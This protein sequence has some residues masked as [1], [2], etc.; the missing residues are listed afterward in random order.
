VEKSLEDMGT[1]EIFLNRTPMVYAL[2]SR[3]NKWDLIKLQSFCNAKDTVNRT[4]Q[5]PRDW[6]NVFTNPTSD[7]RLIS[8]IYKELKKLDPRKSINPIKKWYIEL[9]REFSTEEYRMTEKYLKKCSTSLVIRG[10]QIK[11]TLRF[12]LT[13]VRMTKIKNSDDNRF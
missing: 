4:K 11:T 8:N 5:Q 7:R 9:N 2:K 13:P 3:I 1:G 10:M 6:E 12:H